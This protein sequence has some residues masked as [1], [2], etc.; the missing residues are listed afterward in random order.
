MCAHTATATP[1]LISLI[2]L[3]NSEILLSTLDCTRNW[4]SYLVKLKGSK[5]STNVRFWV[6]K[7]DLASYHSTWNSDFHWIY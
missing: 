3:M 4:D 1:V 2:V 5:I 6:D 7:K